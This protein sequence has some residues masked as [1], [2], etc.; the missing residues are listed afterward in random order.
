MIDHFIEI[1]E[2]AFNNPIVI[3]GFIGQAVFMS[4]FVVQWVVSERAK[5]SIIPISFWY[6]SL[7]G[8]ALLLFY[9]ISVQDP[10]FV[11]GQLFGFIVY[12]RN[13]ILI[14]THKTAQKIE[15]MA[16]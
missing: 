5:K 16:G 12:I 2:K 9:A 4:R 1:F 13:L 10:V 8:S 14:H 11:L 3:V 7:C 6:L 15:D